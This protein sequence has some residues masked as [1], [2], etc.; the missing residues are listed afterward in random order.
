MLRLALHPD[1]L[2]PRIVDL[3]RWRAHLLEQ[4]HRRIDRTADARLQ[5]LAVE[6]VDYPYD[7]AETPSS[8]GDV[9]VPL[10]LR[11]PAGELSLFSIAAHVATAADVTVEELTLEAFYPADAATAA[12]LRERHESRTASVEK[13]GQP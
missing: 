8:P 2:A 3:G 9:V 5:E 10:R 1:G 11:T 13:T 4:L 12:A 6:L 7:A